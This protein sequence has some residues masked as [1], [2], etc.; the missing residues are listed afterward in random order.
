M[1]RGTMAVFIIA[2]LTLKEA[3]RKRTLIGA[4][5]LGLLVL[6]ISL[7]LALIRA[8]LHLQLTTGRDTVD[9]FAMKYVTATS[10]IAGI[11]LFFIR[12][13]GMLFA[14]LMA[15]GSVSG[16]IESGL[17]AVILPKPIR[18]WQI[19]LGKWIGI[20]VILVVSVLIWVGLSYASLKF[21]THAELEEMLR[22][23]P[24]L[25]LY[26]VLM[27][28][29]TLTFSSIYQRVLGTS[30]S[31]VIGILS[32]AD[33]IF[34]FLGDNFNVSSLTSVSHFCG[35]LMP[36]GYVAWWI[37]DGT[38]TMFAA[39]KPMQQS[40]LHS[41]QLLQQWGEKH[42]HYAHLDG[43]Y[44]GAYLALVFLIG[45]FLFQRREVS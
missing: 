42:L 41:S 14:I 43:V 29:L 44:V 8:Q 24:Y 33:G 31:L 5:L 21:Q 34:N 9:V 6:G 20:N 27:S 23:A 11:C 37:K 10:L 3:I 13:L 7:M 18:R 30:L 16:E 35:L 38:E 12:I 19:L 15:G 25:A 1:E 40:P 26:P 45:A 32:Y 36:Q 39:N 28:T 2:G 17:L 22:V 4:L